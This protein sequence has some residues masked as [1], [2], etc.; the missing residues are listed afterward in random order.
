M[1]PIS[2]VKISRELPMARSFTSQLLHTWQN[3]AF[4]IKYRSHDI[5]ETNAKSYGKHKK[6]NPIEK[7]RLTAFYDSQI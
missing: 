4:S 3:F 1:K 2:N 5:A 6:R 7:H